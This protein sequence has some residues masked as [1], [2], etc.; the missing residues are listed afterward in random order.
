VRKSN[1]F[2]RRGRFS[3]HAF[4]SSAAPMLQSLFRF[5]VTSAPLRRRTLLTMIREKHRSKPQPDR[6]CSRDAL[7][8]DASRSFDLAVQF[9]ACALS[10]FDG[11]CFS[12]RLPWRRGRSRLMRT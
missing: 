1:R 8:I 3:S 5:Y 7:P 12:R 11:W 10:S 4:N 6:T 2:A 9:A